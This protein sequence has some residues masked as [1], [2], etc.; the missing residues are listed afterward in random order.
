MSLATLLHD[1]ADLLDEL[2]TTAAGMT[3]AQRIG[4]IRRTGHSDIRVHAV[5]LAVTARTVLAG[6]AQVVLEDDEDIHLPPGDD[7]IAT[8]VLARWMAD[9]HAAFAAHVGEANGLLAPLGAQLVGS[10]AHPFFDP[11]TETV[12]WPNEYT[13]V[14]RTYDRIFG[15]RGHGWSNLQSTHL[16]LP[17]AGDDGSSS[18]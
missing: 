4:T 6:W 16:N 13:E 9:H 7:P 12:I 1:I 10:G 8:G 17:F 14:Y 3:G 2:P 15:V 5:D 18:K 11:A